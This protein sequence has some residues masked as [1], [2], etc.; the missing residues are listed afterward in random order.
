MLQ[1]NPDFVVRYEVFVE[2]CDIVPET[3][4]ETK[5]VLLLAPVA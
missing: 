3:R 5:V 1:V 2:G 4:R